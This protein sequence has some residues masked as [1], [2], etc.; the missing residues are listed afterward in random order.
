MLQS[1]GL[2]RVGYDWVTEHQQ[3][4]RVGTVFEPKQ[5]VALDQV[6]AALL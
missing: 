2:Q 5:C 4:T 3:K 6:L 1:M